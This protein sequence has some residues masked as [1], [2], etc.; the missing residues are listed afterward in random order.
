MKP[1]P[2]ARGVTYAFLV[3]AALLMIAPFLWS[4]STSLKQPGDVFA[5]PPTLLPDPVTFQ[6]YI[7]VFTKLTFD[8]YFLN[9]VIVTGSVVLLNVL[10]GTAAAYAFAKLRFPGRNAIFFLLLLTLMVPFQVNLIPLYKIMVELHKAIPAIGADTYFGIVAPSAIQV[11]GI[12]LMR[13]FLRAIPDEILESARMDGASELRILRSIVFPIALPG[14]ATLAIFTFLGA[15]ND[16]LWPLIVTNS[17]EMRTMPVGLALLARKNAS[18]WGD[19]MAGTVLTA[20]PLIVMFLIL[21]RR[22]IEGLT[23][24]SVKDVG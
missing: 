23:A 15:W 19:T 3:V 12:F 11:F 7:D 21:Q 13:Q 22:F 1:R 24:G 2:L 5:Y 17:D 9:S 18:N 14:M 16:F 4:I 10:F 6:N 20:A 8:R